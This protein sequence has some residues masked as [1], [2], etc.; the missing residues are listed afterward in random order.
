MGN[1]G[2]RRDGA[3][4]TRTA[5]ENT[6]SAESHTDHSVDPFIFAND[7][8]RVQTVKYSGHSG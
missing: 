1:N 4:A 2:K 5:E 3:M 6:R 7:K 8:I